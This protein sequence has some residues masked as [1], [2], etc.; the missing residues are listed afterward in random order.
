MIEKCAHYCN[1]R[2]KLIE[3]ELLILKI[4]KYRVVRPGQVTDIRIR[5]Y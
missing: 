2:E 5:V 3:R 1:L 4:Q